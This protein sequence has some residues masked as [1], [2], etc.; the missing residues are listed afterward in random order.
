MISDV[1]HCEHKH[2]ETNS[3]SF[4]RP[5]KKALRRDFFLDFSGVDSEVWLPDSMSR[6][7][8]LE[9]FCGKDICDAVLAPNS[10]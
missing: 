3:D 5:K 4:L 9:P 6:R 10:N 1:M 8:L 7:A 2:V